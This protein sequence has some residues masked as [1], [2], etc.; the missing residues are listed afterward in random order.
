MR[1]YNASWML[2]LGVGSLAFVAALFSFTSRHWL[3]AGVF[4]GVGLTTYVLGVVLI[5]KLRKR[6]P[7][8]DLERQGQR[9][10]N[11]IGAIARAQSGG[12]TPKSG[13]KNP[14]DA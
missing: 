12:W 11:M 9:A 1:A 4:A 6:V 10:E 8:E 13:K 5:D 2:V 7:Q 14:P 3:A